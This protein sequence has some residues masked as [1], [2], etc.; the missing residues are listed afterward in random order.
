MPT[1]ELVPEIEEVEQP[2]DIHPAIMVRCA[3]CNK[4]FVTNSTSFVVWNCCDRMVE[5][6]LMGIEQWA[7][8][9]RSM[10]NVITEE[11]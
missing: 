9:V 7:K 5:V 8:A 4:Q 2:E 10:E 3:R 6:R 11:E 1:I